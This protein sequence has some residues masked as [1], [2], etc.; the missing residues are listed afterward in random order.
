[1]RRSRRSQRLRTKLTSGLPAPQRL[2]QAGALAS[3]R[4][5]KSI[6]FECTLIRPQFADRQPE[7]PRVEVIGFSG[8]DP[9]RAYV[10]GL[11]IA[12]NQELLRRVAVEDAA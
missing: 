2:A 1:M 5:E 11:R 10:Q 3:H 4:P 6:A 8:I 7:P 9:D 12:L